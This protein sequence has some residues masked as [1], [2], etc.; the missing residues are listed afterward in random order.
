MAPDD[1][2]DLARRLIVVSGHRLSGRTDP[3][4]ATGLADALAPLAGPT[5]GGAPAKPRRVARIVFE[6]LPS[7]LQRPVRRLLRR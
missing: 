1:T 5:G 4:E 3:P 6:R 7:G 2:D